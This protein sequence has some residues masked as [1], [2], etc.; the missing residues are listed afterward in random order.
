MRLY[1]QAQR[2]AVLCRGWR[3]QVSGDPRWR[4]FEKKIQWIFSR[5][6][7]AEVFKD[8]VI[9]GR[10]SGRS[11]KLE[12]FVKYPI[13]VK[14]GRGFAATVPIH[15]A[16]DCKH[17]SKKIEIKKVEEFHGQPDD[18]GAHFGILVSTNGF[19]AGA[20]ARA[21]G[22]AMCTSCIRLSMT[23]PS[24]LRVVSPSV[25]S[26]WVARWQWALPLLKVGLE[27]IT[28]GG[29]LGFK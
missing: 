23:G 5:I 14:F 7:G 19:D 9:R 12:L 24:I 22:Y 8:H 10:R 1:C 28:W 26:S 18:I 20:V 21:K 15:I 2:E 3:H 6:E 11:R 16:V 25:E 13:E 4:W 17:Y 27:H 29:N